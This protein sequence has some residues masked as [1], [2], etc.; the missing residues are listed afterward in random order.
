MIFA[1]G[2]SVPEGPVMLADGRWLV[3]EMGEGRGCITEI[4]PDGQDKR[5]LA[6]TG[7]PNGLAVDIDGNVWVAESQTPS[8]L[9]MTLDGAVEVFLTECDGEAFLFPNDLAFGPDGRLYMTD[10]GI[11]AT[12]FAPGGQV[13]PDFETAPMDGRVYQIDVHTRSI[14]KLDSGLRFT[15]GI[16]FG[17]DNTLYANESITHM[18]YRYAWHDS[19]TIG[20]REPVGSVADPENPAKIQFPD[21]MKFG[22]DGS[23]YVAVFGQGG[24]TV[25]STDGMVVRRIKTAGSSPTNL[26]FGP[27]GSHSIY[28][29]EVELGQLEVLDA[30]VDGLPLYVG[31]HSQ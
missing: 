24:V 4:S 6:T 25:L 2:L 19:D 23:I 9:R 8:L 14:R 7:R 17:P 27:A 11:L 30:G 20:G 12:D 1:S 22:A 18:V 29:T 26:A 10:S 31:A 5:V 15:N 16:C 13:R 28:V 21:G 3:V